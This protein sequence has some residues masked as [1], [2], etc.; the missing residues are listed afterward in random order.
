MRTSILFLLF[1]VFYS[2][3]LETSSLMAQDDKVLFTYDNTPVDLSEFVYVYEKNNLNETDLYSKKSLEEYLELYTNFKLKVREAESMDLDKT[4][5]F[6]Q[7]FERYKKQL[8]Q[9]Y[10]NDRQISEEL[11]KEAHDR[12]QEERDVSH[13]LLMCTPDATPEDTARLYKDIRD[14]R[15]EIMSGGK[16]FEKAARLYSG[17]SMVHLG[18]FTAF[19][20]VYP[21]ENGMYNTPVGELSQPLRT[22]FGYHLVRVEEARPAK[23]KVEVGYILLKVPKLSDEDM[24][25]SIQSKVYALHDSLKRG[26][27]F[28][29]LARK[30]SEDKSTAFNGGRWK[31]IGVG[32]AMERFE[33][34]AFSLKKPGDFS[35][36][37]LTENGWYIIKMFNRRTIGTYEEM[38]SEIQ[39]KVLRDSRSESSRVA[40][41][42]KLKRD[43]NY[44][45]NPTGFVEFT[46]R[47]DLITLNRGNWKA[48]SVGEIND[49][50]FIIDD[51]EI[52]QKDFAN[53]IQK[54]QNKKNAKAR[55]LAGEKLDWLYQAFLAEELIKLEEEQLE[56]RYPEF[57]R[58]LKEYRDGIILFDLTKEKV[59]DKA[60]TDTEGLE[61]FYEENKNNYLKE[62]QINAKVFTCKDEIVAKELA[63]I[64]MK[65]EQ[66][67]K[68]G[69]SHKS[70]SLILS[71]FNVGGE[72]V[73]YE[74]GT[75]SKGDNEMIDAIEWREGISRTFTTDS[76]VMFVLI[77]DYIKPSPKPL[78]E[79]KGFVISDYNDELE[80]RWVGEL[81]EKYPV[82]LNK[83][84]F[85]AIIR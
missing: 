12:I 62:A 85:E 56:E 31:W 49:V 48:E 53:Y 39:A 35:E 17:D 59:W 82:V 25:N 57:R 61:A 22:K 84:V 38:K 77:E 64:L 1:C 72:T 36:P 45:N 21:F 26:G 58:L 75:Y 32:E 34:V 79:C 9:T 44:K 29:D 27:D 83:D 19:Q 46:D 74:E 78:D 80:S 15:R 33:K 66:K 6:T 43:Y 51:K 65:R 67:R 40:Y 28:E 18:Y 3:A 52:Y 70:L 23:G 16:S 50:L 42:D 41:I 7:E 54:N 73:S 69:R 4:P 11:I 20:T 63:K 76:T 10:L 81:R 5:A 24:Q 55:K 2:G 47:I 68:K 14:I 60:S 30:Y 8:S 71:K 37:I 13:I